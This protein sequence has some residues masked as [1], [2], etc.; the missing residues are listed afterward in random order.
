MVEGLEFCLKVATRE[1][2]PPV[3]KAI[4]SD[5]YLAKYED[6]GKT[7]LGKPVLSKRRFDLP[8]VA[9]CPNCG[10]ASFYFDKIK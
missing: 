10:E 1:I 3:N 8:A 6:K 5:L 2:N 7:F 9:Y 4:E